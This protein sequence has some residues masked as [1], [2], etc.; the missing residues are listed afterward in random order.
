MVKFTLVHEIN[1][2]P[3]TFWK[4][5]FDKEFNQ[6]LFTRGLEFPSYATLEQREDDREIFRKVQGI[7]KLN[8][9]GPVAKLFGPNMA[10]VEEGTFDKATKLWRWKMIPNVMGDKVRIEG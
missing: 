5:F 6:Q 2:G 8:L 10:Y 7:P 4:I 3:E 9:P 1:C